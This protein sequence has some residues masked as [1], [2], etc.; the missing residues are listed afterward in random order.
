MTW[1]LEVGRYAN[2]QLDG[3]VPTIRDPI[4]VGGTGRER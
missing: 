1:A 2:N 3:G 4:Q